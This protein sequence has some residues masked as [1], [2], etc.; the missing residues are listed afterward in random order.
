MSGSNYICIL[1]KF[2]GLGIGNSKPW[3]KAVLSKCGIHD[4]E[5]V[6]CSRGLSKVD[7]PSGHSYSQEQFESKAL[8]RHFSLEKKLQ[9][10]S[11][12]KKRR[13]S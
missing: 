2:K 9:Y 5:Q 13:G 10:I 3:S 6:L 12:M 7:M 1:Y 11:R 4:L 8:A